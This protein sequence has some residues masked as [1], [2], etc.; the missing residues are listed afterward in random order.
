MN[1]IADY[2]SEEEVSDQVSS[3]KA[4]ISQPSAPPDAGEDGSGLGLENASF[5]WNEWTQSHA[6]GNDGG[7]TKGKQASQTHFASDGHDE[8]E[9]ETEVSYERDGMRLLALLNNTQDHM[10]ELKDISVRFPEGELTVVT[11]P[12]ASGKTALLVRILTFFPG[13][14]TLSNGNTSWLCSAR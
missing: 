13:V 7:K 8:A 1:R 3:I 4:N 6:D 2:L 10:F 11:G 9:A 14:T 12:T 5:K